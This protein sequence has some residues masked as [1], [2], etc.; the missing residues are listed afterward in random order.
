MLFE[1]VRRQRRN[2]VAPIAQRRQD[3]FDCVE[4]EEQILTE[5]SCRHLAVD[6]GV[7]GREDTDIDPPR[8]RR[9]EALEFAAASTRSNFACCDGGTF[10]ISSRNRVPPSASSNRPTRSAR[11]SV[12]APRTWPNSSLSNTVSETPP[13]FTVTIGRAARGDS[14]WIACATSPLPVPFSPVIRTFAS[15]GAVRSMSSRTGL[16][17]GER[18]I[19]GGAPSKLRRA[20]PSSWRPRRNARL[21]STCVRT[22]ASSRALSHGFCTKSRAP[23]RI[24]STAMSTL[25]HAVST[26]TGS[27]G[28]GRAAAPAGPALPVRSRVAGVVEIDQRRIEVGFV[29]RRQHGRGRRHRLHLKALALEKQLQRFEDVALVVGEKDAGDRDGTAIRSRESLH[30]PP[31]AQLDD[32]VAVLRV[33]LRVRHLDDRGSAAVEL[34]EQ[35]HDF[36]GLI[37]VE[38]AGRFVGENQPRAGDDGAGDAHELLLAAG[39]LAGIQ[40]LF[41]DNL[42]A[43]EHIGDDALALCAWHVAI[44]ERHLEI[45]VHREVVEQVIAL[46]DEADVLLLQRQPVFL[47]QRVH[48]LSLQLVFAPPVGVVHPENVQQRRLPRSRRS[49]DRDELPGLTS[50]LMRRSR[51][52]SPAP[53]LIDFSRFRTAIIRLSNPSTRGARRNDRVRKCAD[54]F[55]RADRHVAGLEEDRRLPRRTD[56]GRAPGRQ[57]VAGA[58]RQDIRAIRHQLVHRMNHQRRIRVLHDLAVEREFHLQVLRVA[59]ELL[60]HDERAPSGRTYRGSFEA[61]SRSHAACLRGRHDR[62]RRF[63]ACTR[64]CSRLRGRS[65]HGRR[66][67]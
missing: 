32:A 11:A 40:I 45:F 17:A 1:K 59:N 25:A 4:A 43:I 6:V 41:A 12:K 56:A 21:S 57:H 30:D 15:D 27:V 23:R 19:R 52:V 26:M 2:V 62:R 13:A 35:L 7:G 55:V 8:A 53:L 16:I 44:A 36:T 48:R 67:G 24:A 14:A 10:A 63:R 58:Q 64:K 31:V 61:P 65:A 29:D 51:N 49:H 22:M 38:V 3:N 18:A 42:K 54:S 5:T 28:S 9:A 50:R 66:S 37:R 46:E 60:R 34:L 47:T 33:G 39:Q 20:A